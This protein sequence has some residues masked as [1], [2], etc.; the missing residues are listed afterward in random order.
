M[1]NSFYF[2]GQVI[3]MGYLRAATPSRL[4]NSAFRRT[5][6]SPLLSQPG[7][8][9]N[10]FAKQRNL[11]TV[12]DGILSPRSAFIPANEAYRPLSLDL[13]SQPDT[14]WPSIWLRDNC[15]C[16]ACIH[17]STRQRAINTF[18]IPADIK[19]KN[20]QHKEN[21]IEIEW[22]NDGHKSVY[23]YE[24]LK[25]H[26]FGSSN[27]YPSPNIRNSD[28]ASRGLA[29]ASD[30][31]AYPTVDYE[32]VMSS[33]E[34]VAEWTAKIY[35]YG[36]CFVKG[37]PVTPEATEKLIERIAFIRHTHYG[38][39][40]DFTADLK[41]KDTAYT[42][43]ELGAHTD[44]TYF[45]EPA[46]LQM[47]HL[48]SHTDGEGGASLLVDAFEAA[49]ILY[50]EDIEAY[51][52]LTLPVLTSHASGNEDVCIQPSVPFPVLY[53]HPVTGDLL[54]VRWNND[55]RAAK[56]YT[57]PEATDLWYRAARKWN[58][59]LRRKSMEQWFQLEPGTPMIFDNWRMLHGRSSFVGKRRMCGAYLNR[60]DFISRYRLL[61]H[62]R[63]KVLAEI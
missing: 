2:Y 8:T 21:S 45:T 18:S 50:E 41:K 3:T 55:D 46:G 49:R 39:F 57:T 29:F 25:N 24:W 40:W 63:Q 16:R 56:M 7:A 38:G 42:T 6:R 5:T 53:H 34:G 28:L 1:L 52:L 9:A 47:L 14:K 26:T 35:K 61:N 59:I 33:D 22:D 60:D 27:L 62:G 32:K 23:T 30:P 4:I 37:C 20:I 31:S 11:S 15:Q 43:E 17:P 19:P 12:H 36:F 44:N 13:P 54:Q 58:E 10:Y 48:L 51:K